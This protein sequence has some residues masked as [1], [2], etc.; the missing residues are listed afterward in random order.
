M[1]ELRFLAT[2]KKSLIRQAIAA[3]IVLT[4]G[5][6]L[7]TILALLLSSFISEPEHIIIW[8]FVIIF[9]LLLVTHIILYKRNYRIGQ[10]FSQKKQHRIFVKHPITAKQLIVGDQ[11]KE[12]VL[13]LENEKEQLENRYKYLLKRFIERKQKLSD[14][15]VL[16]LIDGLDEV[17]PEFREEIFSQFLKRLYLSQPSQ[18]KVHFVLTGKPSQNREEIAKLLYD[19]R[20]QVLHFAGHN[21]IP[22]SSLKGKIR[23]QTFKLQDLSYALRKSRAKLNCL[24]LF[25]DEFYS[26]FQAKAFAEYVDYII[27]MRYPMTEESAIAFSEQFYRALSTG[28]S[29]TEAYELGRI[30]IKLLDHS[31]EEDEEPDIILLKSGHP[32]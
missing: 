25:D 16:F 15:S 24:V 2:D 23:Q 17:V 21:Y 9:P 5:V 18:R 27:A 31:D 1:S 29:I 3:W 26:D 14:A 30:T 12:V 22:G 8:T 19:T 7:F 13:D 4:I 28:R 6:I 20:P 32:Q 10:K 11:E